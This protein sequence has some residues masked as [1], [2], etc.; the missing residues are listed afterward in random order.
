LQLCSIGGVL[1]FVARCVVSIFPYS[2]SELLIV[3]ECISHGGVLGSAERDESSDMFRKVVNDFDFEIGG[4]RL[5]LPPAGAGERYLFRASFILCL[6]LPY[7]VASGEVTKVF[8]KQLDAAELVVSCRVFP[9]KSV[10]GVLHFVEDHV[11][12]VANVD[13]YCWKGWIVKIEDDFLV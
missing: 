6:Q 13:A 1:P 10:R 9:C 11:E 12:R 4:H 5:L 8:V 7:L 3:F 2:D